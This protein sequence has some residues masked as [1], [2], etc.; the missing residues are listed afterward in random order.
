MEGSYGCLHLP[1]PPHQLLPDS[2]GQWPR[3]GQM[4]LTY[5]PSGARAADSRP[6]WKR[7]GGALGREGHRGPQPCLC[8]LRGWGLRQQS[9]CLTARQGEKEGASGGPAEQ[10]QRPT[11]CGVLPGVTPVQTL[12]I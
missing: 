3:S 2:T 12:H 9:Q 11:G 5:Q 8:P 4:H 1:S 6:V 10:A 7:S